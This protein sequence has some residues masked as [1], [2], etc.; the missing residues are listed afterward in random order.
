MSEFWKAIL[1]RTAWTTLEA[2]AGAVAGCTAFS[3]IKWDVVAFAVV[4]A[5]AICIAKCLK[6][7]VPEVEPAE[8]VRSADVI[9]EPVV[10]YDLEDYDDL[11]VDEDD[12]DEDEED[13]V[14]Q[15][16]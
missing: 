14:E 10:N 7:G 6:C 16:D 2:F 8:E 11:Q 1:R 4:V 12:D 9:S 5:D 3:E 13:E 15:E